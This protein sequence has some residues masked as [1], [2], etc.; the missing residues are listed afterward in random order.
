M[1]HYYKESS[2]NSATD[3]QKQKALAEIS[4]TWSDVGAEEDH[5]NKI[6]KTTTTTTTTINSI[7]QKNNTTPNKNTLTRKQRRR[8]KLSE[9]HEHLPSENLTPVIAEIAA[10]DY[11][12]NGARARVVEGEFVGP[13][14]VIDLEVQEC[15]SCRAEFNW[16]NR[17]HHCRHCGKI[18]CNMCSSYRALLPREFGQRDPQR[19]CVDCCDEL[20]PLQR[21][22]TIDIGNHQRDNSVHITS[23]TCSVRRYTNLPFSYT[24][25]SELRKATYSTYN[26]FHSNWM[27]D[28]GLV[29]PLLSRAKGIAYLTVAK[30]GFIL[31]PRVGTGLVIARLGDGR[32]SA[33][34]AIGTAGLC[35]GALL[36]ADLTDYVI[37]LNTLEAVQAFSGIG[38]VSIG[39]ELDVAI[40]SVGR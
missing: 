35:W 38:Q 4:Q 3:L 18:F 24:L 16:V 9:L 30:A 13:R 10:L 36:G 21:G 7:S 26:L 17:R 15:L 8:Q 23:E 19:G 22:L 28:E 12:Y 32:W 2:M 1:S 25:G 39:V 34:T 40:G 37:I 33:P 27:H 11:Y 20:A 29:V 6:G 31:A 5:E 14:W